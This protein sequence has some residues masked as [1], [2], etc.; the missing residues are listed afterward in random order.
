MEYHSTDYL[1]GT[2]REMFVKGTD[3]RAAARHEVG[4][5]V[6]NTVITDAGNGKDWRINL[7]HDFLNLVFDL[8]N[9]MI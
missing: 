4:H 1:D 2:P 5:V 9:L 3:H 6:Q 8:L 7:P